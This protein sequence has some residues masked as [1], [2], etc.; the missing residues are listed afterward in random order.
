MAGKIKDQIVLGPDRLLE[1]FQFTMYPGPGSFL[2]EKGDDV[3][4]VKVIP[5]GQ[6]GNQALGILH[7]I[8]QAGAIFVIVN[9]YDQ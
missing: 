9:G 6:Y 1:L 7:A 4:F 8:L 2:I 5:I 3:T